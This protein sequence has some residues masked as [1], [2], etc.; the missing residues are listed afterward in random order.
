MTKSTLLQDGVL[1][2]IRKDHTM[3]TMHLTNGVPLRGTIKA[4]D[5]FVVI[6]ESDGKQMMVYKHAI[7]TVTPSRAVNLMGLTEDTAN[8]A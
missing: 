6:L 2:Q 7:S 1:N 8:D 4:F 3:I 5:N